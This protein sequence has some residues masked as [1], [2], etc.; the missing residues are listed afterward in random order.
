[1]IYC[2]N[3]TDY[4]FKQGEPATSYFIIQKGECHIEINGDCKKKLFKGN[5][6]GE[7]ALLYGT[8]RSA[9]VKAIGVCGLWAID[10]I[11]F[12]KAVEQI[13]L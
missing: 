12:R 7:L 5:A 6:F 9:S 8:N 11:T 4:I 3:S 2:E 1:M 10:R 13:T